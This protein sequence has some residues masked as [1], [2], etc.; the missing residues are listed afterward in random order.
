MGQVFQHFTQGNR[1]RVAVCRP[2]LL[3]CQSL[4]LGFTDLKLVFT[5]LKLRFTVMKLAFTVIPAQAGVQIAPLVSRLR[6]NDVTPK[7]RFDKAL[8]QFDM[9]SFEATSLGTGRALAMVGL[10]ELSI[11]FC[12]DFKS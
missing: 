2:T 4:K 10:L 1:Q 3:L 8:R 9:L 12:H 7:L 6:G 5:D 11:S